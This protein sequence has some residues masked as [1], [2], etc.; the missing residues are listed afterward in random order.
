[1]FSN[2]LVIDNVSTLATIESIIFNRNVPSP[3]VKAKSINS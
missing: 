2:K 3:V 1:M